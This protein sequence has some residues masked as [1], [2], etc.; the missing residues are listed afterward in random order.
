MR[1]FLALAVA[2]VL[3]CAGCAQRSAQNSQAD[4]EKALKEY[5]TDKGLSIEA[6]NIVV[7]Q[8]QYQGDTAEADVSLT[9]KSNPQ[10]S[11]TMKYVLKRTGPG[12]WQVQGPKS[13]GAAGGGRT[14]MPMP[15]GATPSPLGTPNPS[16]L[17]GP[18]DTAGSGT[19]PVN[20]HGMGQMPP[21]NPPA[22]GS[23]HGSKQP[24][25]PTQPKPGK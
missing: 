23:A 14:G 7:R 4:V 19:A 13:G 6:M 1:M 22:A 24:A 8:V 2:L 5:L 20:P 3:L 25:K 12:S 21:A 11:M 15:E 10:A 9:A 16:N 17:G 18:G